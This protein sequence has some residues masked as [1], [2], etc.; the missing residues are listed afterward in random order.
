[1]DINFCDNCDNLLYLYSDD[2]N[3]LYYGCKVCSN[4]Q[5]YKVQKKTIYK[6]SETIKSDIINTNKNLIND[7]TLPRISNQN[8]KCINEKCSKKNKSKV[9]YIKYNTSELKFIYICENCGK[10]WTNS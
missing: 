4:I 1:M 8:I 10:K 7:V 3:K 6:N 2:E 5:E 9:I